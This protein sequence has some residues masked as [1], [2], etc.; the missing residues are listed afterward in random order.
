M[1]NKVKFGLTNV[2]GAVITEGEDGAITYG[3]PKRIPGGVNLSLTAQGDTTEFYADDVL[4][5]ASAA[6]NGYRGDLEIAR[7]P[8]WFRTDVLKETQDETTGVLFENAN[9]E[10]AKFALLFEFSGDVHHTRHCLY[11][12]TVT[13]PSVASGTTTNTKDPVTDTMTVTSVPRADGIVKASTT[14]KTPAAT[15]NTWFNSVILPPS[16]DNESG[17]SE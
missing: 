16:S 17:D 15:Y 13:R 12:C 2:Y 10:P 5:Y 6:N 1:E 7:V 8:G 14:E 11:N 3:T 4:Y 9:V